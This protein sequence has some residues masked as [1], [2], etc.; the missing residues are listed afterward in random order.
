MKNKVL[1]MEEQN[2]KQPME[3]ESMDT[4]KHIRN[5][6]EKS[7]RFSS[8][9][10]WSAVSAGCIAIAGAWFAGSAMTAVGIQPK[11]LSLW[12]EVH[13]LNF[14][15]DLRT[16][17]ESDIFIIALLTFIA[18]FSLTI[19]FTYL[20]N[21][22]QGISIWSAT[23]KRVMM[24]VALPMLVSLFFLIRIIQ[25]GIFGLI[26]PVCL[27]FYGLGLVNVGKYS[28]D[29]VKYLGF[30]MIVIGLVN[31]WFIQY[32]LYFWTAGFGLLHIVYGIYIW[33]KYEKNQ[34]IDEN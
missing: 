21:R 6:M 22:K 5:I 2:S 3:N 11:N 1:F 31:C 27:L 25:F 10:G 20:R 18:A 24:H 34:V 17:V 26:P 4:L 13:N 8:L 7:S 9:S 29:E 30:G 23:S 14:I 28:L 15:V 33:M 16:I 19:L 12:S 32:G